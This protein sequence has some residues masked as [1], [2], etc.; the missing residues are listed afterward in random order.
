MNKYKTFGE[1]REVEL[2]GENLAD[3][4][5]R[6]GELRRP[7]VYAKGMK[8]EDGELL[9]VSRVLGMRTGTIVQPGANVTDMGK[10][11]VEAPLAGQTRGNHQFVSAVVEFDGGRIEEIDARL[12]ETL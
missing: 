11:R 5:T 3:A 6:R 12:V 8:V 10:V 1:W 9:K 4:I 7:D 2:W